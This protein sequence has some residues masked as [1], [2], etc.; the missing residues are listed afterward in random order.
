MIFRLKSSTSLK[1]VVCKVLCPGGIELSL[2]CLIIDVT[3]RHVHDFWTKDEVHSRI[4][5]LPQA[6]CDI[7]TRYDCGP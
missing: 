6:C 1:D 2:V 3:C 7:S 5:R 4:Y